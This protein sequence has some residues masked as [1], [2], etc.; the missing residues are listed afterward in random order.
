MKIALIITGQLRT[1]KL[2]GEIIKN[3]IIDRY[4]TDVFLSINKVNKLQYENLNNTNDSSEADIQNA[5][6]LYKPKDIFICDNYETVY[7][8]LTVNDNYKENRL[9]LEQYYIVK[10][11]YRLL[12]NYINKHNTKYDAIVRVR[13]D[14]FIWSST[15]NK[16]SSF[17][18]SNSLGHRRIFYDTENIIKVIDICKELTT[19]IDNPLSNEIYAFGQGDTHNSNYKWVNDQFWVHS[20]ETIDIIANFYDNIIP[21]INEVLPLNLNP[22]NCPYYE[23]ILWVFLKRNGI[24]IQNSKVIGE[25]CNEFV[26]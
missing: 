22:T 18:I 5:V 3:T 2:C 16:L 9:I 20:M 26:L 6:D 17:V 21:I 12:M 10:Q 1:Y 23:L 19:E 8:N 11:G 7:T 24:H 13:F 15:S 25:F 14:Q 4:D